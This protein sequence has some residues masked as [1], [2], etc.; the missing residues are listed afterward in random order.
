MDTNEPA[1][2]SDGSS[3]SRPTVEGTWIPIP[4][5]ISL[6]SLERGMSLWKTLGPS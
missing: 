2:L 4:A 6:W 1:G 5:N 3:F